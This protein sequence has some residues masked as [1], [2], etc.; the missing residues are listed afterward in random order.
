[1]RILRNFFFCQFAFPFFFLQIKRILQGLSALSHSSQSKLKI[2]MYRKCFFRISTVSIPSILPPSH[3]TD[4]L[5]FYLFFFFLSI[6]KVRR[7]VIYPLGHQLNL[8]FWALF[9]NV[10][11]ND[12][13]QYIIYIKRIKSFRTRDDFTKKD[14]QERN[15]KGYTNLYS[16]IMSFKD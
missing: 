16:V 2:T 9:G 12:A 7:R 5:G 14:S 4:V 15:Q 11:F 10:S 13:I 1:M 8:Y 6:I 3:Q